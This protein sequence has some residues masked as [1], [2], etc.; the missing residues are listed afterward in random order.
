MAN[1][2]TATDGDVDAFLAGIADEQRRRDAIALT[3]LMRAVTG[4]PAVPWAGASPT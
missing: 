3:E 2:T 1:K 4:Q